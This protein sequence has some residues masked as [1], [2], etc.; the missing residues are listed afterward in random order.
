[1][2]QIKNTLGGSKPE[3]LYAWKKHEIGSELKVLNKSVS[4]LPYSFYNG[5]AVVLNGEIHILGSNDSSNYTKHYK[6]NGSSWASVS[7]LPYDFYYGSAVVLNG[8]IHILGGDTYPYTQHYKWNGSSWISVSTLPYNFYNGAAVVLNGEIHILGSGANNNPTRHYKWNGSRWT[9]VSTLPYN[10]YQGSAV[11]L[12]NEIHILGGVGGYTSHYK[13]NGSSWASVSTLP[14][15]F[16]YGSAVVLEGSIHI[17]G[18]S[19]SSY[20]TSHYKWNG[21]SWTSVSTLPYN[22][23]KGSAVILNNGIHILGS[24][25]DSYT[26]NHYLVYGYAPV[27]TFLDYIVSDKETAFPDGGEKGGYWYEKVFDISAFGFTKFAIDEYTPASREIPATIAGSTLG[28]KFNHSLGEEPKFA[29]VWCSGLM[30]GDYYDTSYNYLASAEIG[31]ANPSVQD[32]NSKGFSIYSYTGKSGTNLR[33]GEATN[34]AL[35][36]CFKSD[37]IWVQCASTGSYLK[38]GETYYI[39]TFA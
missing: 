18:T 3:G 31:V 24:I 30:I 28:H 1:M 11:V 4:T 25:N 36:Y 9:S 27:Y 20:N 5:C 15:K 38:A 6:W 22:F 13:W 19:Y 17:L 2:L 23:Y 21:S 8:E 10:F 33:V 14:H 32:S 7:T 35:G 12:N 26:K 37:Y 34:N 39:I 29:I 16:Y